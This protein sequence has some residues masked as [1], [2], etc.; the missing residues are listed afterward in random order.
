MCSAWTWTKLNQKGPHVSGHAV[1]TLH[2]RV[3]LFSGL[4]GPAGSPVTDELWEFDGEWKIL[5]A[6]NVGPG[7]RMYAAASVLGDAF[8]VFG[9]WNPGEKGSGGSFLDDS[10]KL[11]LNTLQW[12]EL[13]KLPCGPVSRHSACSVNDDTIVLTTFR[14][15][16]VCKDDRLREQDTTGDVPDGLSMCTTIGMND[17]VVLFGGS[18][19]SQ[20][21]SSDVYVLDSSEWAWKLLQ[22]KTDSPGPLASPCGALL[23]KDQC[24]VFGGAA[25]GAGGYE[26]G[27]GLVASKE[28]WLLNVEKSEWEHLPE[29]PPGRVAGSLSKYRDGFLLQGGWDPKTQGTYDEPWILKP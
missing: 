15:V 28:A 17:K 20:Q 13:E 10:W 7:P 21:L 5:K 18:S 3:F 25:M 27:S 22:P 9:G 19:K 29:G 12:T 1:G 16:V 26:G 23:S 2:D 6:K 24:L 11:D 14:G 4:T 8:Y